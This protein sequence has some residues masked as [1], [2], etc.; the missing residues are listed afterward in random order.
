MSSVLSAKLKQYS[1]V[2]ATRASEMLQRTESVV[3]W[4]D[5]NTVPRDPVFFSFTP[6][7]RL[8]RWIELACESK[9]TL[10]KGWGIA[11][12]I[13]AQKSLWLPSCSWGQ[14]TLEEIRNGVMEAHMQLSRWAVCWGTAA[15]TKSQ[16]HS[17]FREEGATWGVDVSVPAELSSEQCWLTSWL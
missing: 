16:K 10:Q 12:E 6:L 1:Q 8:S 13:R 4:P 14:L 15:F 9:K 7:L 2:R 5:S 11:Y 17:H 3:W